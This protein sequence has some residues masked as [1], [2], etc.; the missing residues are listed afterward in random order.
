[1]LC[2]IAPSCPEIQSSWQMQDTDVDIFR[3][4][5][6]HC[7][8]KKVKA[9]SAMIIFS[10]SWEAKM[11]TFFNHAPLCYKGLFPDIRDAVKF[12]EFV[13]LEDAF[14]ASRYIESQI[15]R[16][17]LQNSHSTNLDCN[18]LE[19]NTIQFP[20]EMMA[21]QFKDLVG[22]VAGAVVQ[23]Q[24]S[25]P[26]FYPLKPNGKYCPCDYCGDP[27]SQQLCELQSEMQDL[28]SESSP[29]TAG[30]TMLCEYHDFGIARK[31]Y[32]ESIAGVKQPC[33]LKMF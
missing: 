14:K 25:R 1:M 23:Q 26:T 17:E 11:Q 9:I 15:M 21:T 33:I 20:R 31:C 6:I 8:A 30:L 4:R 27:A 24:Y 29:W 19:R 18:T 10:P 2:S 12:R 7:S 16:D 5:A 13:T 3:K 22:G 28:E 32:V